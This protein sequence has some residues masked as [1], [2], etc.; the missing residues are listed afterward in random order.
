MFH[1]YTDQQRTTVIAEARWHWAGYALVAAVSLAFES[2]AAVQFWL[3]PMFATKVFQ[4]VQNITEHTGLTHEAD[5]V[6]N[7]RTIKTWA[8][9]RWLAWNM[10]YHTAH[11]TFPAVPFHKLP[12]LHAELVKYAGYEPLNHWLSRFP[13]AFHSTAYERTRDTRRCR[14][15]SIKN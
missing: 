6:R 4:N 10:R 12:E 5:T 3:A 15:V 7:T 2:W 9:F 13:M 1:Y 11:H 14:E 8:V